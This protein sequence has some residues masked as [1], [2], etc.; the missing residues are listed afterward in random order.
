MQIEPIED[1]IRRRTRGKNWPKL[2][3]FERDTVFVSS[4]IANDLLYG[5]RVKRYA[6]LV[7][8]EGRGKST[9]A[10]V[11]G[12]RQFQ[13]GDRVYVIDCAYES[14][15]TAEKIGVAIINRDGNAPLWI[16]DDIQLDPDGMG[17]LYD[18]IER[19]TESR[20]L[21]VWRKRV[22]PDLRKITTDEDW[23]DEVLEKSTVVSMVPTEETIREI[24][25]AYVNGH[26][27]EPRFASD[28][29]LE[30]ITS[31]YLSQVLELTGGNLQTLTRY[32]Q[33]WDP[34]K[35][36][37]N[38]MQPEAI[39][40]FIKE[41][42]LKP[43]LTDGA[44][45]L[46]SYVDIAAAYQF[47]VPVSAQTGTPRSIS[48]LENKGLIVNLG[49]AFYGLAHSSD[50]RDV[51]KAFAAMT[52]K[53]PREVTEASLVMHL[54]LT[55]LP[56]SYSLRL[57]KGLRDVTWYS[58][59]SD[60]RERFAV[61]ATSSSLLVKSQYVRSFCK[62]PTDLKAF[63]AL[64][65]G[66]KY[67][68]QVGALTSMP[69]LKDFLSAVRHIDSQVADELESALSIDDKVAMYSRTKLSSLARSLGYY[70]QEEKSRHFA[71]RILAVIMKPD[72]ATRIARTSIRA[73]GRLLWSATQ[74]DTRK[75]QL[76]S[77]TIAQHVSLN[78]AD[79]AEELSL[80]IRNLSIDQS[81]RLRLI[82]RVI[83][84]CNPDAL[85]SDGNPDGYSFL[86]TAIG[87]D[88]DQLDNRSK[89]LS[90]FSYF[91]NTFPAEKIKILSDQSLAAAIW[92]V[93][94]VGEPI[95]PFLNRFQNSIVTRLR[96]AEVDS[97][98]WL[99]WSL[100]Q[101]S[102]RIY[103]QLIG[104][105]K[106]DVE[107]RLSEKVLGASDL[108]VIGLLHYAATPLSNVVLS[109]LS[110]DIGTTLIKRPVASKLLL[111]LVGAK[112]AGEPIYQK[113]RSEIE[114]SGVKL[115]ELV[116][117]LISQ[118]TIPSTQERLRSIA[119]QL[120]LFQSESDAAP[121]TED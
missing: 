50:A 98:L 48:E 110:D 75:A 57:M 58:P 85:T 96:E 94:R 69:K 101:A 88:L 97:L 26:R 82:E 43:L 30:A 74:I 67:V 24:I 84:E 6:V 31:D 106:P 91:A 59:S 37:L 71:N 27:M 79:N 68:K 62:N 119:N 17:L 70:A 40:D 114:A 60:I 9:A 86:L 12:F 39:I 38:T 56:L 7:G 81:A 118:T 36:P 113:I 29:F 87:N 107:R 80:L 105:V 11:I 95:E 63:I 35:Q 51:I 44:D 5:L 116:D 4:R 25:I 14:S 34:R 100:L 108:A 10:E 73:C 65:G 1:A 45:L 53:T 102:D 109:N 8:S 42:R 103:R 41:D 28:S 76:I 89:A 3:D 77:A 111:A 13:S 16:I 93:W 120:K 2:S 23:L 121:E 49:D 90:F 61:W 32:L 52:G 66:K 78:T 64:I 21:F 18:F 117:E 55:D 115:G 47:D 33:I 22:V 19:T 46:Q 15:Q 104:K 72:L 83:T 92:N 112:Q 54:Q 99:L 20:F